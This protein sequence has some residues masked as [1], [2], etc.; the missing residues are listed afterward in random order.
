LYIFGQECFLWPYSFLKNIAMKKASLSL[1]D[2][3]F[4]YFWSE[5]LPLVACLPQK[6]SNEESFAFPYLPPFLHIFGQECF[7][8]S[9]AF[10]KNIAKKL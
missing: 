1:S 5:M 8:W 2:T 7:L 3:F 4:A 10:L 9:H 6:Y